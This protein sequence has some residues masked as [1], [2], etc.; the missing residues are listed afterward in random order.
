MRD[1]AAHVAIADNQVDAIYRASD[2][3]QHAVMR[4]WSGNCGEHPRRREPGMLLAWNRRVAATGI[5]RTQLW[6]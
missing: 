2:L 5:S 4:N 6:A 3:G 1:V